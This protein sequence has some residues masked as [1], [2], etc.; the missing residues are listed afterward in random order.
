QPS[1][2]GLHGRGAK[3]FVRIVLHLRDGFRFHPKQLSRWLSIDQEQ[4]EVGTR[5]RRRQ[6]CQKETILLRD[7]PSWTLIDPRAIGEL[8][9]HQSD[10]D[11]DDERFVGGVPESI[12]KEQRR[13]HLVV[14]GGGHGALT[15]KWHEASDGGVF[16]RRAA[17]QQGQAHERRHL[18]VFHPPA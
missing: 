16:L 5:T 4:L 18:R 15:N 14:L 1:D 6:C 12:Q 17:F 10:R 8:T 13:R 7:M 2:G 9:S 11:G 3:Q